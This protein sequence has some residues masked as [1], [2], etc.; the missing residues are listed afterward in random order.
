MKPLERIKI[1]LVKLENINSILNEFDNKITLALKDEIKSKPAILMH[2][3]SI[4]EQIRKLKDDN[5]FETLEYFD[6]EDL[7]GLND[8]R[9][10]IAHDY[11]GIDMFIIENAIRYGLPNLQKAVNKILEHNL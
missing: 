2:L 6:K 1:I 7:K 10:F 8:V 3:V 4:A 11:E 9:N 5:E